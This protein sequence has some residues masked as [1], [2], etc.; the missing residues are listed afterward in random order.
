M[1]A[2][3]N[4]SFVTIVS[5]LP[6]SGTSMLMRMLGAGGIEPLSDDKREADDDNPHGYFE[7]EPIRKLADDASCIYRARGRSV[8]VISALLEH[9]PADLDY[10]VLFVLRDMTEVLASQRR[11]LGN[12]GKLAGNA[13]DGRLAELFGR[14][15]EQVKSSLNAAPGTGVL[16]LDYA[17][18]VRDPASAAQ[19][20]N[21]FLGGALNETA[22]AAAVSGELYRNRAGQ[23]A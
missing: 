4:E 1:P 20:I 7:Y 8:K 23:Q 6:R 11:M 17:A 3:V 22:M 10:R 2:A 14:H 13:D 5:G 21:V 18:T 19:Q 12:R 15:L 16:Y 9:L